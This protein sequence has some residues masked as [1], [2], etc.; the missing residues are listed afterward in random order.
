MFFN[1]K[2]RIKILKSITVTIS[3]ILSLLS[4]GYKNTTKD[5][6][7]FTDKF[8]KDT[9]KLKGTFYWNFKLMGGVQ[10]SIHSFYNDSIVYKM[11]GKVYET[12]YTMK[13][14]SYDSTEKRWIGQDAEKMIYVLFFKEITDSTMV[15]YKRKC[16]TKGLQE[17]F[18]LSFPKP[19]ATDNHGWNV[20]RNKNILIEKEYPLLG[21]YQNDEVKIFFNKKNQVVFD[22]RTYTKMS[23][24]K[25]E[26]RWA[27]YDKVSKKYLQIFHKPI[28]NNQSVYI[29]VK[30]YTNLEKMY[31]TEYQEEEFV[32]YKKQ[33]N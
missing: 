10:E 23:Y 1:M 33:T 16:K 13:K 11:N 6:E 24:H 26:R 15:I 14:L 2:Q 8:K 9:F 27:G 17:A 21:K 3:I 31:K 30:K 5:T 25:G 12:R 29:S 20:Y 28:E 18:D 19:D 22:N 7:R 4:C 32:N